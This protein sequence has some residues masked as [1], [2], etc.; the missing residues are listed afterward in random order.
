MPTTRRQFLQSAAAVTASAA[1]L[2]CATSGFRDAA[3]PPPAPT[4]VSKQTLDR[5]LDEPGL[6]TDFLTGP[7]TVASIELL[8]NG[9]IFLL[10]TRSSDGAEAI[11]VPNSDRIANVYP[12]LLGQVIP[13]FLNKDA[14][15]LESL[16]WE[17]YRSKDNYKYQGLALWVCVAAVEMALLELM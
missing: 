3:T 5:I 15:T 12:L 8:R 1:G 4:S 10:R 17:V 13:V 16:L 14:R 9:N 11:T 7:V 2:S 6:K